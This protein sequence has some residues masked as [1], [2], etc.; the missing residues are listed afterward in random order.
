[1]LTFSPDRDPDV[2]CINIEMGAVT[3][4]RFSREDYL[5]MGFVL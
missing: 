2:Y 1:M 4:H 5:A 3:Y